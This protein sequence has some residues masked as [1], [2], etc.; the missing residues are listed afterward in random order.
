MNI[1]YYSSNPVPVE[2]TLKEMKQ[3]IKDYFSKVK[4]E[5]SFSSL[6]DYIVSRAIKEGKVTNASNTQYS[7][8]KM[9]PK[10]SILVSKILWKYIWDR[11]VFI[12]FGENPY[13]ANYKGD[14][15]F[16]IVK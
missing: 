9:S 15:R 12:A 8:N 5:F 3:V 13:T 4:D 1:T 6:S 2:Y 16:A 7:S 10:S 11:K 14:T